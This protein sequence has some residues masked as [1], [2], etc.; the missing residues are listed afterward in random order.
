M[1]KVKKNWLY[2][3]Q[4]FLAPRIVADRDKFSEYFETAMETAG[5]AE[6]KMSEFRDRNAILLDEARKDTE[7]VI[8][9]AL[10]GDVKIARELMRLRMI[11]GEGPLA[12]MVAPSRNRATKFRVQELEAQLRHNGIEP[13]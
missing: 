9:T 3:L 7:E 13:Q 1:D 8:A 4:E 10:E 2:K 12:Q 5:L 6:K 11:A